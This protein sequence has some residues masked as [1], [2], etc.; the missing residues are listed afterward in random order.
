MR[1]PSCD[2]WVPSNDR[3]PQQT[4]NLLQMNVQTKFKEYIWLVNT[5]RKSR[6]ITLSEINEKWVETEMS[7]GVELARSTFNRHKDAIEEIF[8]IFIDCDRKNGYKYFIGNKEVLDEDSI[9]SWM[10]STLSVSNMVSESLSLQDRILLSPIPVEGDW[11]KTIL[12][13]MKKSVQISM[14]YRKY[15]SHEPRQL[16]MEP[17]CLKLFKQRWYV[18]GHFHRDATEEKE[19]RDYFG[20][21]SFDRIMSLDMT[22]KKFKIDPSF[23]AKAYF[24]E[25]YGV[26]IDDATPVERIVLR[27]YDY[28]RYYLRDL[29]IH[30]SQQEIGRGENFVDF[31]LE[32]RPTVDFSTHL[33]SR[34]TQLKVLSPQW[35]ADEIR[36][37][38]KESYE[39]Y[40]ADE[41]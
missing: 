11:L 7:G 9:Q 32:M 15:G 8:G 18:L 27:A 30:P 25:Y 39:M 3:G 28:E 38:H 34:G 40:S 29:P 12:E 4:K 20:I 23:D 6:R 17:Y 41:S 13:A 16:T 5:I 10:M 2:R 31:A 14:Y 19:E 1:S 21:F 22:D 37:L 36:N 35:L 24:S 33:I 26:L